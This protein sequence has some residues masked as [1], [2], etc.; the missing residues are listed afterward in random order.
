MG[1]CTSRDSLT[2]AEKAI[3][4]C[5]GHLNFAQQSAERIDYVLRKYSRNASLNEVQFRQAAGQLKLQVDNT[6]TNSQITLFYSRIMLNSSYV[7]NRL[8][9][10]GILLGTGSNSTKA[11]LLFEVYDTNGAHRLA[12]EV[13]LQLCREVF[14]VAVNCL[15]AVADS[16]KPFVTTHFHTLRLQRGDAEA[17]L[18]NKIIGSQTEVTKEAFIAAFTIKDL[19]SFLTSHGARTFFLKAKKSRP[20]MKDENIEKLVRAQTK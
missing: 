2:E 11:R 3:T 17:R 14:E 7:L 9:I 4:H 12:Y 13:I 1:L 16:E 6:A 10:T 18:K 8:L 5:E 19:S 20:H 15:S